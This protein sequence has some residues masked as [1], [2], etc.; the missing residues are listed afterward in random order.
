M[1]D[2]LLEIKEFLGLN[3]LLSI[4]TLPDNALVYS[5]IISSKYYQTF[6]KAF[7]LLNASTMG[8]DDTPIGT[9]VHWSIGMHDEIDR[10]FILLAL[11]FLLPGQKNMIQ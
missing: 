8:Q 6:W 3:Y 9:L 4:G 10:I 7:T 2:K 11:S 1:A 5:L